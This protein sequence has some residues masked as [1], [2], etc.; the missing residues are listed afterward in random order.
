[1][2]CF[3]AKEPKIQGQHPESV[4]CSVRGSFLASQLF[5]E[6]ISKGLEL[7]KRFIN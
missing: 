3:I 5:V 2:G 7:W 6:S 1:M 4:P